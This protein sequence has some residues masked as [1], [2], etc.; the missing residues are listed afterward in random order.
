MWMYVYVF[1]F[2]IRVWGCGFMVGEWLRRLIL[3][4]GGLF[5]MLCG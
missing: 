1:E 3:L 5:L 2:M 4:M